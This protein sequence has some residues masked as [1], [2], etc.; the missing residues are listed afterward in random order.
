MRLALGLPLT[1]K[2]LTEQ[3]A[4][5]RTYVLRLLIGLGFALFG[6]ISLWK[7]QSH[8]QQMLGPLA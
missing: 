3:A 1:G 6:F 4:R 2:E 5:R 7:A 8:G